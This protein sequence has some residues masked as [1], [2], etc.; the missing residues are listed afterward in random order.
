MAV[1]DIKEKLCYDAEDFKEKTQKPTVS[2]E[3]EKSYELHNE[4]VMPIGNEVF[5][6]R[7]APF[8]RSFLG[9]E[10]NDA[11]E[12]SIG[13]TMGCDDDTRKDLHRTP[14]GLAGHR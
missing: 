14:S 12:T 9:M 8:Q 3:H 11:H 6:C 2:S 10:A 5:Q 1:G 4:E 7:A 13:S